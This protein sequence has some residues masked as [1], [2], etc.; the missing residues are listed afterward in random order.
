MQ[1]RSLVLV[2]SWLAGLFLVS[3]VLP[4]VDQSVAR[5]QGGLPLE[6]DLIRGLRYLVPLLLVL[7]VWALAAVVRSR[8]RLG[9]VATLVLGVGWLNQDTDALVG[10]LQTW[11]YRQRDGRQLV[12]ALRAIRDLTPPGSLVL[13]RSDTLAVRYEAL[14]AAAFSEKDMNVLI[15]VNQQ[16]FAAF[17]ERRRRVRDVG[18]SQDPL[19]ELGCLD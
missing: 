1:K 11:G 7:C 18:G 4:T 17:L 14:R 8:E 13:P 16:E 12:D 15:Y 19:A 5:M 9:W 6:V 2:S 3:C 10:R